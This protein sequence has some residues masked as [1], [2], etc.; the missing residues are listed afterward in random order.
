VAG[1]GRRLNPS[2]AGACRGVQRGAEG[3]ALAELRVYA[4]QERVELQVRKETLVLELPART[5]RR[6]RRQAEPT[7]AARGGSCWL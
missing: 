5:Q 3:A 1:D 6:Q 2:L 4:A 7:A